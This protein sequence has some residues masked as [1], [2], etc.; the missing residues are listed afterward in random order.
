MRTIAAVCLVLVLAGGVCVADDA[1]AI[2]GIKGLCWDGIEKY[3]QALPWLAEHDLNF[4]MLC[5]T[6]FPASA[7]AWRSD[8]TPEQMQQIGELASR[9]KQLRVSLCLSFNP[10]ISSRPPL[11]YSSEQDYQITLDKIK[12]VHGLGVNWFALCLDDINRELQPDDKT[13]FGT[14]QAAQVYFVNRLWRDMQ[15]L[16]PRPRLIFCPSVY[17]T[18]DAEQHLDYIKAVGVGIDRDVM[19]FWTGPQCCSTRITAADA[20]KFGE[21]I[22][23]KPFVWDNYPVND[24]CAWRPLVSPLRNRSADLAGAVAG[25]MANPMRQW[26]VSRIPLATTAEYLN[27]PKGYD[28]DKAIERAIRSYPAGQQ[29]AVRLLVELYGSRF[30]GDPGFPN[31]ALPVSPEKAAK[32][33]PKYR[34]L[35][36]ELSG[37]PGLADIWQDCRD[38]VEMDIAL[39]ERMTGERP[40][41]SPLRAD[42]LDFDGGAG[43]DVGRQ[44]YGRIV[45]LVYAKPTGRDEMHVEFML[46]GVPKSAKL[47]LVARD[48][49][50]PAKCRVRISMNGVTVFEGTSQFGGSAWVE[51]MFDIPPK[52]LKQGSNILSITNI[53][54]QGPLGMPPWFMVAEAEIVD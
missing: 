30:W 33:L 17:L 7:G 34:A 38:S 9:A 54:P 15:K 41:T 10:G 3:N 50:W 31:V 13:R 4:L 48:D 25:Y 28:P 8:Y 26:N 47:R 24:M 14:L 51:K 27:D 2:R 35:R 37:K 6:S 53:E 16:K 23:R 18:E 42:G 46:D 11:T 29:R 49:G 44:F 12:G 45:N 52:A 43:G 5:Y 32:L 40:R 36:K 1:F 19:M 39:L 21:W 20:R 22:G